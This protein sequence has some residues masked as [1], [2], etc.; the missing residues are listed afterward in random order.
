MGELVQLRGPWG[1]PKMLSEQPGNYFC[2]VSK[3][4]NVASWD[5]ILETENERFT[6]TEDLKETH[7]EPC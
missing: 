2:Y 4:I 5:P 1:R 7:I 3:D 6:L